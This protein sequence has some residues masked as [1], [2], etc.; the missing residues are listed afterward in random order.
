MRRDRL[1]NRA[2]VRPS[3]RSDHGRRQDPCRPAWHREN[4][5]VRQPQPAA[6][7]RTMR[8]ASGCSSGPRRTSRGIGRFCGARRPAPGEDRGAV[9][10]V[11]KRSSTRADSSATA[12]TRRCEPAAHRSRSAPNAEHNLGDGEEWP[13]R[14]KKSSWIGIDS[15]FA[16]KFRSGRFRRRPTPRAYAAAAHRAPATRR[17]R[18][19]IEASSEA[20]EP[21]VSL[22]HHGSGSRARKR[23][24]PRK[25]PP[26]PARRRRRRVGS[27]RSF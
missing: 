11:G 6:P 27:P 1:Q 8:S 10:A 26:S 14:S 5:K 13:P 18:S 19:A 9:H 23:P 24:S 22:R 2:H 12:G 17:D 3:T 4:T 25:K 7:P 20:V 16:A 21:D 15:R